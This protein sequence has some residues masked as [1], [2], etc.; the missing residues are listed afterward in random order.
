M[1]PLDRLLAPWVRRRR[2]RAAFAGDVGRRVLADLLNV[3][4]VDRMVMV[5]ESPIETGFADG[6][7]MAAWRI[8]CLAG[9]G[10]AEILAMADAD[11]RA[12]A[13]IKNALAYQLARHNA[14]ALT[15][16]TPAGRWV[17][18]DLDFTC[19]VDGRP[20]AVPGDAIASGINDGWRRV[21]LRIHS[22]LQT[23]E[24]RILAAA[25]AHE[26]TADVSDD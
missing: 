24:E 21:A 8:G 12:V 26:E 14:Y 25:G 19:R 22:I 23:T 3:A 17:L 10:C 1:R 6:M 11:R 15:F 16:Q 4:G 7:R 20:V 2:Y 18:A 9:L 5:A 13:Q